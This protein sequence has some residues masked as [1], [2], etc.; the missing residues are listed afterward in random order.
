MPK[1]DFEMPKISIEI[2]STFIGNTSKDVENHL[3]I[4]KIT[5]DVFNLIEDNVTCRLFAQ[6]LH[7]DACEWLYSL[8]P[9]TI[10]S[11]DMLEVLGT[12][13]NPGFNSSTT[14]QQNP[15]Y[16]PFRQHLRSR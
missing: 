4:F 7:G 2:F 6:N 9:R 3:F 1:V 8:F 12:G 5:C 10:T 15:H 16:R 13:E 14:H 11:W